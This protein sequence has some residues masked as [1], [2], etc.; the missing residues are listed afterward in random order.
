MK[1]SLLRQNTC[2]I[3]YLPSLFLALGLF[4]FNVPAR[5]ETIFSSPAPQLTAQRVR[6]TL[7]NADIA[8]IFL[9]AIDQGQFE[10]AWLA[11]HSSLQKDW[12]VRQMAENWANAQRNLG[13]YQGRR[14][15][16]LIGDTV[17]TVEVDFAKYSDELI[18]IFNDNKE[19]IGI[20]F[21]EVDWDLIQRD[22]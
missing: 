15:S 8:E 6:D 9:D 13:D 7:S 1:F 14:E 18:F 3:A 11:L 17:V 20:D 10:L 16:R 22:E 12:N 19:I 21:P 5:A 4:T 2:S